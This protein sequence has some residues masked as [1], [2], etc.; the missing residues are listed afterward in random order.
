[1]EKHLAYRIGVLVLSLALVLTAAVVA[2]GQGDETAT[3]T[4]LRAPLHTEPSALS[5][6]AGM[7]PRGTLLT[8]VGLDESLTWVNVST[9]EGEEGWVSSVYVRLNGP[10][11]PPADGYTTTVVDGLADDW[12]RFT[13]PFVDETGDSSGSVDI[14]AV[15]SFMSTDYLYILIETT[16]SPR[17][18]RL[19]LVDIVTNL[20]NVYYTYQYA[21]PRN[22]S[23]TLFVI[24]DEGGESRD[25]SGAIDY[26]DE[27]IEIRIPLD[28]LDRPDTLNLVSVQVQELTDQGLA[29][30]DELQQVMPTVVTLEEEIAL[31]GSIEGAR[32]NLRVAPV[33]GRVLRV[34]TPGE[35]LAVIGR[36][37]GGAWLFVRMADTFQGWVTSEFVQTDADTAS[38]PVMD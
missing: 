37:A 14:V 25:A 21:L 20:D 6:T 3:V 5:E 38:L 16:G 8:F 1:M 31:N 17:Q 19:V 12:D 27:D 24:T 33:N 9:A 34:V 15:R 32:V 13:R 23:G 11:V 30:T 22:Q 26:R 29:V 18:A 36:S 7:L 4:S 10:Y 2:T 35:E 28:L